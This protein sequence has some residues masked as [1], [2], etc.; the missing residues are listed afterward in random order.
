MGDML[1]EEREKTSLFTKFVE[2][3]PFNDK[4]VKDRT[5]VKK[6][7]D[8]LKRGDIDV[9]AIIRLGKLHPK[10]HKEGKTRPISLL[11]YEKM[12]RQCHAKRV[13]P[14]PRAQWKDDHNIKTLKTIKETKIHLPTLFPTLLA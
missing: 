13:A 5:L 14:R 8:Q 4:K 9:K 2:R 12:P 3:T 6:L 11:L 1:T 7:M 10:K